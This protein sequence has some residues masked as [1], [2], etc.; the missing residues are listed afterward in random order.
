MSQ[1]TLNERCDS[2]N[3]SSFYLTYIALCKERNVPAILELIKNKCKL[4]FVADRIK[5]EQ[6]LMIFKSLDR[7]DSLEVIA[8]K[9]RKSMSYGK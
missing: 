2:S 7:D 3:K 4:D 9:S 1:I 6:W 5:A 8:I